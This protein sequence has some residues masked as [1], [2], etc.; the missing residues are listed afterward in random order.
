MATL[1]LPITVAAPTSVAAGAATF[2]GDNMERKVVTL[3]SVG[4]ATY[5]LQISLK[6]PDASAT[7][8]AGGDAS[9]VNYGSALTAS[10][11]VEV[12]APAYWLRW[13]CTA[14]TSGTPVS[15]L[16]GYTN[17]ARG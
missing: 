5:Q 2:C 13:N 1:S 14:Y 15:R 4:T 7:P 11:V 10:G 17:H 3:E 6:T 8:P 9:W 16:C 12:T